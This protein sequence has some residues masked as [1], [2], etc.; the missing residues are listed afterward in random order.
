MTGSKYQSLLQSTSIQGGNAPYIESYYEQYLEAV[1]TLGDRPGEA[2]ALFNIAFHRYK[3]GDNAGALAAG[4]EA[5][6]IY[7]DI[8]APETAQVLEQLALW[9]MEETMRSSSAAKSNG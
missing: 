4:E 6:G 7:T 2:R 3:L 9:H 5:L 8:S 1:R